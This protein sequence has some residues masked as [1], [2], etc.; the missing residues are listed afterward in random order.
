MSV[1]TDTYNLTKYDKLH[2]IDVTQIRSPVKRFDLLPRWRIKNIHKNN[3]TKAGNFLKSTTTSSPTG[4]SSSTSLPPI[5]IAF[6][7]I[8]TSSNNHGNA[9]SFVSWE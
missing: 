3:G 2:L 4:E 5:G 9:K 7:Y 1:G 6:M 8:E